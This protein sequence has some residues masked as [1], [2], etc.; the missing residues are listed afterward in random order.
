MCQWWTTDINQRFVPSICIYLHMLPF[1]VYHAFLLSHCIHV[2]HHSMCFIL[3]HPSPLSLLHDVSLSLFHPH[4]QT[5][6]PPFHFGCPRPAQVP[7]L[8][9][10]GRHRLPLTLYTQRMI[11]VPVTFHFTIQLYR[12]QVCV[13][14][15]V[16][17]SFWVTDSVLV[18][19]ADFFPLQC[20]VQ[21]LLYCHWN[22]E[23]SV[24]HNSPWYI[25]QHKSSS[26]W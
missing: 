3:L 13:S 6:W 8:Q 5:V 7:A 11:D 1:S 12:M 15:N 2:T 16:L 18:T 19:A 22:T 25:A 26:W 23:P 9:P 14:M 17:L 10:A 20:S 21:V 24:S 4:K